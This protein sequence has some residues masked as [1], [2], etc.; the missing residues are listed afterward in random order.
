MLAASVISEPGHV[1]KQNV[2]IFKNLHSTPVP[3]IVKVSENVLRTH[4]SVS[5]QLNRPD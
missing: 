3:I 5:F 4:S 1:I 2:E